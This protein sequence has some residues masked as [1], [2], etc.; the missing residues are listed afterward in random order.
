MVKVFIFM[1]MGYAQSQS[2]FNVSNGWGVEGV[3]AG[4]GMG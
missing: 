1:F 4:G 3:R 2:K